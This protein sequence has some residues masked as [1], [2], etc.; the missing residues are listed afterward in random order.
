MISHAFGLRLLGRSDVTP[1]FPRPQWRL[2][3]AQPAGPV[4]VVV[5][6]ADPLSRW[7]FEL[8]YA[9]F[10]R[11]LLIFRRFCLGFH[12]ISLR[13]V[14][15]EAVKQARSHREALLLWPTRA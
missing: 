14:A 4:S 15:L 9:L 8:L 5:E 6:E 7:D 10:Q 1:S 2:S 13:F 11:F 3:L 12:M